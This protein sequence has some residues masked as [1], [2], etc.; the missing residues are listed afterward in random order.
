MCRNKSEK[1]LLKTGFVTSDWALK[2][3]PPEFF[4]EPDEV[5]MSCAQLIS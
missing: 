1:H 3:L 2:L 5:I 4:V